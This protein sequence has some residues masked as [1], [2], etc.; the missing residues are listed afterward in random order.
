MKSFPHKSM[1]L[2]T[3]CG[4]KTMFDISALG[5]RTRIETLDI[6]LDENLT[7]SEQEEKYSNADFVALCPKC[8]AKQNFISQACKSCSEFDTCN[9]KVTEKYKKWLDSI[10]GV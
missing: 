7:E 10:E 3:S 1:G 5:M 6:D 2:C 9:G 4:T 8:C